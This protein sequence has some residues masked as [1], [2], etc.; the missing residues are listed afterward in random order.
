MIWKGRG[1]ATRGIMGI[2]GDYDSTFLDGGW[3]KSK[4]RGGI[5]EGG[6]ALKRV[7]GEMRRLF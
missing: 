3:A 1:N 4:T 6:M 7:E 2:T 5:R